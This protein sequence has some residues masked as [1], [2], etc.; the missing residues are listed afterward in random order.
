[1]KIDGFFIKSIDPLLVFQCDESKIETEVK[2]D[3]EN[4]IWNTVLN[5]PINVPS[6]SEYI[7]MRVYDYN[8]VEANEIVGS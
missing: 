7:M 1:M 4:P 3:Q 2:K 8:A 5:L 6:V